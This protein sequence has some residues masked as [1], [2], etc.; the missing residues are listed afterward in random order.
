MADTSINSDKLF[1]LWII[2]IF[3]PVKYDP[4]ISI[5]VIEMTWIFKLI[6]VCRRYISVYYSELR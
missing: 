2:H 3:Y 4:V 5:P 1:V 6:S